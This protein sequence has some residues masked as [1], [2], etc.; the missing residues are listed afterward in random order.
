[1]SASLLLP[2]GIYYT[3]QSELDP[4]Q[5]QQRHISYTERVAESGESKL[6]KHLSCLLTSLFIIGQILRVSGCGS[7]GIEGQFPHGYLFDIH[8]IFPCYIN[9]SLL[10]PA[11]L[12]SPLPTCPYGFRGIV[13]ALPTNPK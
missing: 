8:I 6:C 3:S 12:M 10:Y 2:L 4:S 13:L 5:I 9:P 1:M 11:I 7:V